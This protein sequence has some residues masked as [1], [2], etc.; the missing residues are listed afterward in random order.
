[1]NIIGHTVEDGQRCKEI[2]LETLPSL[3]F[4]PMS[5]IMKP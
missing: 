3:N 2:A 4:E 1:M 5:M